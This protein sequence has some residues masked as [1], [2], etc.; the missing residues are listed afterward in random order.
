MPRRKE[1]PKFKYTVRR[2]GILYVKFPLPG[3]K[4]PV[5]RICRDETQEAVSDIIELIKTKQAKQ[6]AKSATPHACAQFFA[7]YLEIVKNRI[8][9]RTLLKRE[10]KIRLYLAPALGALPLKEVKPIHLQKLYSEMSAKGLNAS[11]VID[12]HRIA[13]NIF[14]EAENLE[15]IPSNPARKATP[16][17]KTDSLKIKAMNQWQAKSFLVECQ[18]NLH[19]IIFEFALETGLRPGEY[20]ALRWSDIDFDKKTANVSRAVVYDQKGGGYYFK[21]TKT[22]RGRRTIPL[23]KRIVE[24]LLL[25]KEKQTAYI[26]QV[27]ERVRRRYKPSRENRREYNKQILENHKKLNLVFS[28]RDFTPLKDINLGRR[29]FKPIAEK[30]RLDENLSLYSLRHTSISLL[31]LAGAN[32]KVIS[33]RAGHNSVAFTMD[34]YAHVLPGMG[35]DATEKLTEVLYS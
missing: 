29:Y 7:F 33:E 12:T 24:K 31:L 8:S 11:T 6:L 13:S 5:W 32:I 23:S 35:E 4:Y 15:M 1:P 22:K 21:P 10:S 30:L 18:T 14:K 26:R 3:S 20:L 17:K 16:P 34:T 27:E 25:H 19:G 2:K 28:S 9:A